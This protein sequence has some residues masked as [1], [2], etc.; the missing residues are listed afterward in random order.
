MSSFLHRSAKN[1]AI[2][3]TLL[4]PSL[5]HASWFICSCNSYTESF[6]ISRAIAP[7]ALD[8]SCLAG[9]ECVGGWV[10]TTTT[11]LSVGS[12]LTFDS[13]SSLF[14][15]ALGALQGQYRV[16][17]TPNLTFDGWRSPYGSNNPTNDQLS[18]LLANRQ[19][20]LQI[21][22]HG[23][24]SF[25]ATP[26]QDYYLFLDG[27]A[28]VGQTYQ[29]S[30]SPVPEPETWAMLLAGLGIVTAAARRKASGGKADQA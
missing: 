23:T 17:L 6:E 2:A 27:S 5:A 26:D 1:T 8:T 18:V 4:L 21:S 7:P 20:L 3:A 10:Q 29:L 30:I 11:P 19:T 9:E 12:P 13:E 28:K 24:L 15:F 14:G 25:N 22:N 16:T